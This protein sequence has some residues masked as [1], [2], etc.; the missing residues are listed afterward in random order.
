MSDQK[1][2]FRTKYLD[3]GY[4][5]TSIITGIIVTFIIWLV[6]AL[7]SYKIF[8]QTNSNLSNFNFVDKAELIGTSIIGGF[9][10]TYFGKEKQLLNGIYVGLGV[11]IIVMILT[12]YVITKGYSIIH[13]FN[14]LISIIAILGCMLG[15]IF[16]SYIAIK[17][18]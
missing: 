3:S 18:T 6:I 16:G 17:A 8:Q 4:N 14:P 12:V 9:I 1:E 5:L 13:V 15:P 11:L 2:S 7:I 10:A